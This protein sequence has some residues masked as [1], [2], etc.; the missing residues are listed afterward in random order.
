MKIRIKGNSVRFR[1]SKSD[2]DKFAANGYLEETTAFVSNT[3]TYALEKQADNQGNMLTAD[4]QNNTI[5]MF[6]PQKLMTEWMQT[7][8]VGFDAY[9]TL[10]NGEKLYLLLEKDFKCLDET[11]E[12]QSDNF[13]NPNIN[14]N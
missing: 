5:T 4:M 8:K 11:I 7:N 12:D 6:M 13:D 9:M 14:M 3:L 2:L 1:L 10:D